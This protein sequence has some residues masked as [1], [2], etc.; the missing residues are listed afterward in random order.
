MTKLLEIVYVYKDDRFEGEDGIKNL[1]FSINNIAQHIYKNNCKNSIIIN[2]VEW[3]A[4]ENNPII[5][6]IFINQKFSSII[7]Y[8][9]ITKEIIGDDNKFNTCKAFNV[10]ISR[11]KCKFFMLCVSRTFFND[12]SFKNLLSFLT[13]NL[14]ENDHSKFLY[15]IS[16]YYVNFEILN[17]YDEKYLN[18][19][20]NN[21]S[22]LPKKNF[23][24]PGLVGGNGALLCNSDLLKKKKG[25]N[26]NY[27]WG[28]NDIELGYRFSQKYDI[29][30]LLSE[31]IYSFDVNKKS[32]NLRPSKLKEYNLN[33]V[34]VLNNWGFNQHIIYSRSINI[35]EFKN[36]NLIFQKLTVKKI[37]KIIFFRNVLK[38]SIKNRLEIDLKHLL[39]FYIFNISKISKFLFFSNNA[40]DINV[41]ILTSS[42][43]NTLNFHY[44]FYGATLDDDLVGKCHKLGNLNY[45]GI[46][47]IFN[48]KEYDK[49]QSNNIIPEIIFYENNLSISKLKIDK[50]NTNKFL[51]YNYCI[52]E[53]KKIKDPL[54]QK[55]ILSINCP[56][57][58]ENQ[59]FRDLN[60]I[61]VVYLLIKFCTK[62]IKFLKLF[63]L[64]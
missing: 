38:N 26:E 52:N 36:Y 49:E 45:W 58:F 7:K 55:N 23:H 31:N 11:T 60:F 21:F 28:M 15:S 50:N 17:E 19:L 22:S 54:N 56:V 2:V 29:K 40:N 10:A 9:P 43:K 61:K 62:I 14:F 34:N 1:S 32:N 51:I 37:N 30:N 24:Y 48:N 64:S 39:I 47:K 18:Y 16:R 53:L 41:S 20:I 63:R 57:E 12:L 8:T 4:D 59:L 44:Y 46:F 5:N 42:I 3:K 33:K 6:K 27:W 13:N 35:N 25:F